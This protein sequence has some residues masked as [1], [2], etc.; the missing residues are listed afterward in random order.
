MFF[1]FRDLCF[2]MIRIEDIKYCKKMFDTKILV[3]LKD[4]QSIELLYKDEESLISILENF[5]KVFT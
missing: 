3:Y 1:S 5:E 2:H 4:N